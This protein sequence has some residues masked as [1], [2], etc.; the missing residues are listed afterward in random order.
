[1][2]FALVASPCTAQDVVEA[3]TARE[4]NL[5]EDVLVGAT[6]GLYAGFALGAVL[7][8]ESVVTEPAE[9]M[10]M[11]AVIIVPIVGVPAG[12]VAGAVVHAFGGDVPRIEET[13]RRVRAR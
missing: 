1:M 9:S 12:A 8:A 10:G 4:Q 5:I 7:A 11:L 13:T 6:W 2:A 3:Q